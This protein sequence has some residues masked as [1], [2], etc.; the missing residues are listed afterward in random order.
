MT[1]T[2]EEYAELVV[3]KACRSCSKP[4][5]NVEVE[6]YPHQGGWPVDGRLARQWLYVPCPNCDYQNSLWKLGV[7]R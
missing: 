7:P 1:P 2:L 5:H 4:M 6:S 3:G